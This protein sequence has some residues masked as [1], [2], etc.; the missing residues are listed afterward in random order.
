MLAETAAAIEPSRS[1]R[2]LAR[3]TGARSVYWRAVA[4]AR[5]Q[6]SQAIKRRATAAT[7]RWSVRAGAGTGVACQTAPGS[8]E[9]EYELD[10]PL[11][12]HLRCLERWALEL[13]RRP[14]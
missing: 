5:R 1:V 3:A 10:G 13:E 11:V 9:T 8:G 14:D 2:A 12:L 7:I 6:H 4:D